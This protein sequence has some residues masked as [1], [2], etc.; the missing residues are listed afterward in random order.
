MVNG[1]GGGVWGV[2][3]CAVSGEAPRGIRVMRW[4]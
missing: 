2:G 4:R 1:V 3:A